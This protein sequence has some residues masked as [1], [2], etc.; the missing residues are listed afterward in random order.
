MTVLETERLRVA[1]LTE[2]D[3]PFILA[4]LN[5]PSFLENIGD[6][7]VRSL[8]DAREYLRGGPLSSYEA[9]GFGLYR[10]ELRDEGIPIGICG[11][12]RR[13]ELEDVDVGFALFPA[14]WSRGYAYEAARAVLDHGRCDHGLDRI[15]AITSLGNEASARLLSRLGF[16]D[17]GRI[18]FGGHEVRLFASNGAGPAADAPL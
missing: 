5:E 17:E 2:D 14:F 10:V 8:D 16:Q 13:P 1:R 6:K 9:N 4:L 7:G 12:L 15:V 18:P 11:L 3:A